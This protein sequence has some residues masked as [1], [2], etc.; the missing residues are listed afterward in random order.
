[1]A[2]WNIGLGIS[3]LRN[4]LGISALEYRPWNIGLGISAL[5]YGLKNIAL[6]IYFGTSWYEADLCDLSAVPSECSNQFHFYLSL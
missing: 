3:A 6:E 1:M 2:I 5:E 4:G